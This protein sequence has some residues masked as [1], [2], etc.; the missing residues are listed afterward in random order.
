MATK[1]MNVTRKNSAW[2]MSWLKLC[3]SAVVTIVL[4]ACVSDGTSADDF[5]RSRAAQKRLDAAW[6]YL[7][8][9]NLSTAKRHIDIAFDYSPKDSDVHRALGHYYDRIGES[10]NAETHYQK[11]ISLNGKNGAALSDYGVYL[12]RNKNYDKAQDYFDRAAS[13]SA[14]ENV[15]GTLE[16][17]GLCAISAGQGEKAEDFFRRALR[18]NPK[19]ASSLLE[20]GYSEFARNR[21]D[22]AKQYYQ[23][24]TEVASD[25]SRSLWLGIQV[26]QVLENKDAVA[27]LALKL[28]RMFPD[29]EEAALLADAQEKWRK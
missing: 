28:E 16:N 19:Q 10:K 23:R 1:W 26:N 14:Y 13:S 2:K 12:C 15:A 24:Y 20:L 6:G 27:S 4:S 3:L 25:T 18:I 9:N 17:A 22:R 11:A 7:A 8:Q 21:T 5:D 29:S